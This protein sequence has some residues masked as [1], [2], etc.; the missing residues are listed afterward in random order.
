MAMGENSRAL[1]STM[2]G[3]ATKLVWLPAPG[4]QID[5]RFLEGSIV[6]LPSAPQILNRSCSRPSAK[7]NKTEQV[8]WIATRSFRPGRRTDCNDSH[9]VTPA[10][11]ARMIV[12]HVAQFLAQLREGLN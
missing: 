2:R 3:R 8:E 1:S 7:R 6:R 11:S 10:I 4:I 12:V 5:S 9:A